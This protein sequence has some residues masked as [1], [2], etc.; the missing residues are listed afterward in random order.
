LPVA[1]VLESNSLRCGKCLVVG[2]EFG[3]SGLVNGGV[4]RCGVLRTDT[5]TTSGTYAGA[6]NG[7][8]FL[9][10]YGRK[11]NW[12]VRTRTKAR[13]LAKMA[14]DICPEI[15]TNNQALC[16][17]EIGLVSTKIYIFDKVIIILL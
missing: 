12:F 11:Y 17:A 4:G 13:A 16:G 7:Y 8:F 15:F 14:A 3:Y 1:K 5:V 9:K 6:G 2:N 10:I